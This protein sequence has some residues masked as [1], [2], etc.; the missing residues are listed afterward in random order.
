M[1]VPKRRGPKRGALTVSSISSQLLKV[2]DINYVFQKARTLLLFGFTPVAIYVGL[3]TE[4][5]P[6]LWD[7]FNLWE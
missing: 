7:L 3:Q 1:P 5:K 6:Q 4:P 2:L